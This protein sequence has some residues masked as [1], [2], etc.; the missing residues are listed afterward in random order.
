MSHL[1]ASDTQLLAASV[2]VIPG[3]L[4]MRATLTGQPP[5]VCARIAPTFDELETHADPDAGRRSSSF[6]DATT[7]SISYCPLCDRPPA[8][9]D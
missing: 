6:I 2:N 1:R 8:V 9:A 5:F 7:R 4:Y 3:G